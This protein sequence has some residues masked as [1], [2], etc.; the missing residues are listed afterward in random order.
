MKRWLTLAAT[1]AVL[2]VQTTVASERHSPT[3][4]RI[5][6]TGVFRVGFVPDAPPMSF[7]D[8]NGATTGYSIDL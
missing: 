1:L 6:E 4:A 3:L 7:I 8:A 2:A 5:A